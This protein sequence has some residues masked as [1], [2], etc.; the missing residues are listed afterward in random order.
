M[1]RRA[2]ITPVAGRHSHLRM[3]REGLVHGSRRHD[4]HIIVAMGD[5]DI[6][7]AI[8]ATLPATVQNIDS[9][10]DLL[11]LA[12]ARNL[13]A[14]VAVGAGADI[15]VFLDVDCIPGQNLLSRYVGCLQACDSAALLC[16]P[17]AY[18]PPAPGGYRL[19]DLSRRHSRPPRA[20]RPRRERGDHGWR[21][22]A[23]LVALI[24]VACPD[25]VDHRRLR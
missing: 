22:P 7:N 4:L 17:V 14:A 24:C 15:L 18:L 23:L 2:I 11:P 16:G 6:P 10:A 19:A 12:R 1:S 13:G 20:S 5:P 9:D 25:L 8:H 3:Q 21:S